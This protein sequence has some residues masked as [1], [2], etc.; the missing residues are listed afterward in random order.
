MERQTQLV[1]E[2]GVAARL[3]PGG[4]HFIAPEIQA[5][6]LGEGCAIL[7]LPGEFFVETAQAIQAAAGIRHLLIAC[8]ANHYIY[9][10]VP[11]HEYARG[12][13]ETGTTMLTEDAE[14]AV[15][16]EALSLLR[17]VMA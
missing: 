8:Y 15:R 13:Y 7:G 11:A 12:G 4:P 2:R 16:T 9:Y 6:R 1:A 5:I 3:R 17:E 14:A 10:V